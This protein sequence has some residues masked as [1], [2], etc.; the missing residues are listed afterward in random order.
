LSLDAGLLDASVVANRATSGYSRG[1]GIVGH[2]VQ[3][4]YI[5]KSIDSFH[6]TFITF[7]SCKRRAIGGSFSG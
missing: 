4:I 2:A 3:R 7:E 1:C 6:D 5:F